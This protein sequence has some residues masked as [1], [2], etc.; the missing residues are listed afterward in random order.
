MAFCEKLFPTA[1]TF[2]V[3]GSPYATPQQ[4]AAAIA[5]KR[6]P[7]IFL[8]SRVEVKRFAAIVVDFT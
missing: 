2:T 6:T 1:I 5:A 3:F 4:T 7:R 8:P